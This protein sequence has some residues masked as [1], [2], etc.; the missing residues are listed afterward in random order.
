MTSVDAGD[1]VLEALGQSGTPYDCAGLTRLD[2]EGPQV[3][4]LVV[5][6]AL[7][8][9]AVDA[10][11]RGHWHHLGRLEAGTLLLGPV[12]GA[13]Y[14][15]VARPVR[16]C[17]VHRIGLRELYRPAPAQTWAYDEYGRPPVPPASSPLEHALAL[18]VGRG[19]SVLFQAPMASQGAA[20]PTDDDVLWMRV[21]A[22]SV[23]Y[24]SLYGAEAAADLLMDPAVWQGMVDQQWRLLATLERWIEQ[25]E[26]A[27]ETRTAE[28]IR[29]GEAVRARAD[30]T[31]LASIGRS[32]RKRV[33]A[34]DAD[35]TYAACRIVAAAAGITPAEP[36]QQGTGGDRL[37][38]VERIALASR[39]RTR[40]VRLSGRWWRENAGP[41]VGQRSLSGGAGGVA[42]A[43][44]RLCRGASGDRPGDAGGGGERRGVRGAR[45]DVLP[46]S[47]R[48]AARSA[49]VAAVH[50]ARHG[51]GCGVAGGGG[52]GDGGDRCA[53]AGRDGQGARRVCA[54]GA[55]RADRAGVPGGDR[56]ERGGGGVHAVAEPDDPA[57]GGP[58]RGDAATRGVGPAAAAADGFLHR[59]VHG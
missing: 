52:A 53:G 32:S 23:Q 25:L 10:E 22:G 5:R 38:P 31:L 49:G 6:G 58:D 29:A 15:L 26:R 11:G 27:H 30:R 8:L 18:G 47:A 19:L 28:G 14:T 41:L 3:L 1:P 9:F 56:R 45:G 7:D 17:V 54:G 36:A 50:A 33:T 20:E 59:A 40:T 43:A 34:A 39:V 55:V 4:W 13:A 57:A 48:P 16:D 12:A 35:A 44:R 37:D 42:V 24:G 46:A 21:P 51:R 2:L